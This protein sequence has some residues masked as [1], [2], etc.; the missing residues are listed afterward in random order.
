MT[1]NDNLT[2]IY[3]NTTEDINILLSE[4][5]IRKNKYIF[6]KNARRCKT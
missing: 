6:N 5:I 3:T 2:L 4:L 1:H